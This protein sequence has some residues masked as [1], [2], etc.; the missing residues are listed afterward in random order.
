MSLTRTTSR[1]DAAAQAEGAE[2][3]VHLVTFGCQM[4]KYDSL[5][6]EGRFR[7]AG[8]RITGAMDEADVV[9]FNTCS[10]REHAEE[11]VYSWL[12]E[13]K[14]EKQR[15][16]DLTIGVL[17]C[18]AQRAQEEVFQ[19]AGHVDLVVGT[20]RFHHLPQLVQDV[21]AKRERAGSAPRGKAERL[22]AVEM[23]DDVEVPRAGEP[24]TG[25]LN[26]YLA[27][28]RGCDLN[29]T[30]CIVPKTRGRVM[31]RPIAAL[32][33]EARWMVDQGAKVVTLLGQTVNSYGEDLP[34]P[35]EGAALGTG[36]KGRPSLADLIREL[37]EVDGLE[38]I[39]LITLHPAY[40]TTA[41]AE[42]LRDCDKA[43][44]FLPLPAQAG[45]DDVLRAMKRGYTTDLYR[46]RVDLLREIVPDVELGSDWI[47]GFPGESDADFEASER[48]LSEIGFAQNYV[49]K[50][51]PRPETVAHDLTD[52]VP[53]E[54]KKERNRR[55]LAAA[56]KAQL[57]RMQ[58]QVG[59]E[60]DVFVEQV[61]ERFPGWVQAR[62]KHNLPVSFEAPAESVGGWLR[63]RPTEATPF[64]LSALRVDESR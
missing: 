33:D 46:R 47:V 21:R 39:R 22:L 48:F 57:L 10:V 20:R 2:L 27:V 37:Q 60:Q 17:G 44:R 8:Y 1:A 28:M 12:G 51:D 55:L 35:A 14:R 30:Y 6:V 59:R 9:L 18:L 16:P 58:T 63:V 64:G 25:G 31:S 41:L 11:R 26:G 7:K 4:N 42:A 43:D 19:R 52:D 24:Y 5:L 45:S 34:V 15:R 49:F 62:S 56:E 29:C 50:Y 13:L 32:A 61:S 54:V 38:R 36:R 3:A 40:V 23:D 53:V